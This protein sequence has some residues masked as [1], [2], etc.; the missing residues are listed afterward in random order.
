MKIGDIVTITVH[1]PY[2][3]DEGNV[4]VMNETGAIT[5]FVEFVEDGSMMWEI[6]TGNHL[7][8]GWWYCEGEFRPATPEE[9]EARLRYVLM[10]K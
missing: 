7:T 3:V 10:K 1:L 6:T 2:G 8:T 5:D 4:S 9:I